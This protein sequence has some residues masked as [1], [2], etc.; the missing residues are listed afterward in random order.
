[1]ERI[2]LIGG[3]PHAEVIA[4]IIEAEKRFELAGITD[5]NRRVGDRFLDYEVIGEQDRLRDLVARHDLHSGIV[6]VGDNYLREKVVRLIREQIPDFR[7][8]TAIH[9]SAAIARDVEIGEGSVIM[10]GSVVNIKA[11][12]GRFCIIN[13]R[14]SLEHRSEMADFS[15]LSAGV[16]TG[17]FFK[18]GRYSALALGVTA[19]DHVSVGENVVVGSGS[20]L[21]KDTEDHVMMYGSPAR[22]VRRREPGER[23]LP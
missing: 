23:F 14:S 7:F 4:D 10:A 5:T 2:I 6:A 3:G 1:M 12:V 20:L 18:L 11:R 21:I 17:G 15:S 13:T 8:E 16:T 19:I 9:P 22:V